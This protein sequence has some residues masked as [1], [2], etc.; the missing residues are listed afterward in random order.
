MSTGRRRILHIVESFDGQATEAWLTRMLASVRDHRR[1][2]DWDFYCLAGRPGRFS[3]RLE[4]L[5]SRLYM[6]PVSV[7]SLPLLV[8][9]VRRVLR[10]GCY[11]VLHGHHDVMSAPYLL[12]SA[13]LGVR[14]IVHVHN[15][16]LAL[17]TPSRAKQVV[18]REPMRRLCLALADRIVGVSEVALSAFV[19]GHTPRHPRDMVLHC[20]VAPVAAETLPRIEARADIRTELGVPAEASVWLF[21][22]RM[23]PYKNPRFLLDALTQ[24]N[25]DTVAI[26]AGTGPEEEEVRT[27]ASCLGLAD[28]VRVLGWRDDLPRLMR[29]SDVLLWPSAEM[30]MEGLGLGVVEAQAHGLPVV[31]SRSVPPEAAVLT[32]LV[33]TVPLAAGP[34]AW[35]AAA[36]GITATP[37]VDDGRAAE[38]VAASSFGLGPGTDALLSLY[39]GLMQHNRAPRAIMA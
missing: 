24:T 5:G 6:A 10:A 33:Q 14:R 23:V 38:A 3:G 28:R 7:S 39:D 30:P 12:S 18:A 16:E 20:A 29:G 15:T 35:A 36:E 17:P 34:R 22:G 32:N 4:A 19:R 21:A 25:P 2:D 9:D 31:V 8:R 26:F 1:D 37:R 11:H 13:G 27:Y